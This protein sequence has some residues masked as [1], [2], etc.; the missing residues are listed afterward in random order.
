MRT[1]T[2]KAHAR[3]L[4]RICDQAS[5]ASMVPDALPHDHVI[6]GDLPEFV[7][8]RIG[9]WAQAESLESALRE[10]IDQGGHR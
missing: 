4:R 6:V 5:Y 3:K 7:F 10:W 9:A 8:I 2:V 1:A